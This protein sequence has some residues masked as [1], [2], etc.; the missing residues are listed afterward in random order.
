MR[1]G[2]TGKRLASII[3][4]AP[5]T[6]RNLARLIEHFGPDKGEGFDVKV[7]K[8]IL[9]L[10]KQDKDERDEQNSLLD[11]FPGHRHIKFEWSM[12]NGGS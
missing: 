8:E 2:A 12:P 9:R 5:A 7:L 11:L 10:R 1:P 4:T 3:A 6:F